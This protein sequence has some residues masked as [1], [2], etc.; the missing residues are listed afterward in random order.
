[1]SEPFTPMRVFRFC[2]LWLLAILAV[3]G[4]FYLLNH[5][6]AHESIT[7]GRQHSQL[8]TDGLHHGS[9]AGRRSSV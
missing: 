8:E 1:M 2:L 7:P 9:T 3:F 4:V 5:V 6:R